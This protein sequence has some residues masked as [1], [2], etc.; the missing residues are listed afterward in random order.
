MLIHIVTGKEISEIPVSPSGTSLPGNYGKVISKRM[1]K[2]KM[3]KIKNSYTLMCNNCGRKGKYDLGRIVI[4]LEYY[5]KNSS[6][7]IKETEEDSTGMEGFQFSGYFRCHHCNAAGQWSLPNVT[8]TMLQIAVIG[9]TLGARAGMNKE[10]I[11]FGKQTLADGSSFCFVTDAEEHYLGILLQEPN[12][13]WIWNRLGNAYYKGD[14]QDLAVVAYEQSLKYDPA[15]ME[16]HYSLGRILYEHGEME[17]AASHLRRML[18]TA[19]SYDRLDPIDFRNI[20]ARGLHILLDIFDDAEKLFDFIPKA[21]EFG[22][23]NSEMNYNK[24]VPVYLDLDLDLSTFEGFY[25]IAEMYMGERRTEL[26][27]SKQ[28]LILP[29]KKQGQVIHP[30]KKKPPKKKAKKRH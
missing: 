27:V 10:S 28:T 21:N 2:L 30:K 29:G 15:Q 13:A 5:R 14:R 9:G 11:A 12:N 26:A 17:A 1:S 22:D 7:Q 18:L 16:S 3:T 24:Q 4:D 8:K 25:P 19:R 20:L 6:Q 23:T